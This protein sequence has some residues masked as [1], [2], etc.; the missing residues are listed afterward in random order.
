MRER[1]LARVKSEK[2][3]TKKKKGLRRKTTI[4]REREVYTTDSRVPAPPPLPPVT[5]RREVISGPGVVA[6]DDLLPDRVGPFGNIKETYPPDVARDY[7]S[8]RYIP[9]EERKAKN[10]LEEEDPLNRK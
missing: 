1:R 7:T 2:V 9:K 3:Y 6:R 4:K 8:E 5:Q 10:I